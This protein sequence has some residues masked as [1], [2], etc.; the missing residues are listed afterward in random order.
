MNALAQLEKAANSNH[1]VT[2]QPSQVRT[3]AGFIMNL[4]QRVEW[5]HNMQVAYMNE[6]GPELFY[7]LTE[8]DII[9]GEVEDGDGE[10]E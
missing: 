6:Y 9:E 2:L 10:E 7:S 3:V 4:Q 8:D 5:L 1:G